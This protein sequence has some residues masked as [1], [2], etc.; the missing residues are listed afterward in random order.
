MDFDGRE[1]LVFILDGLKTD[2]VFY[3]Y[4][5]NL[6]GPYSVDICT[7]DSFIDDNY[8]VKLSVTMIVDGIEPQTVTRT[9]LCRGGLSCEANGWTVAQISLPK[10]FDRNQ[11][12]TVVLQILEDKDDFLKKLKNPKLVVWAGTGTY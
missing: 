6:Q 10:D 9:C 12:M 3:L 11:K 8:N 5:Q 7:E 1:P 4:R 2:K